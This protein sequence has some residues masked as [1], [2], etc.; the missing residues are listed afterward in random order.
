MRVK[1]RTTAPSLVAMTTTQVP[2]ITWE[3]RY[4]TPTECKKLQSMEEL[5]HLPDSVTA[6]YEALGNAVNVKVATLVAKA[7]V[8]EAVKNCVDRPTGELMFVSTS[9]G[10]ET[11]EE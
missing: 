6:T 8:G 10:E 2:S 5:K 3:N 11:L 1:R 4:M 9:V 7:L